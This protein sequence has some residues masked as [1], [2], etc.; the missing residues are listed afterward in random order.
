MCRQNFVLPLFREESFF[1][2]F[3]YLIRSALNTHP[4][5]YLM[6]CGTG[7]W[8]DD[9]SDERNDIFIIISRG[10]KNLSLQLIK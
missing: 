2:K 5:S 7:T 8:D 3:K 6:R 1:V 4:Q 10:K 9:A